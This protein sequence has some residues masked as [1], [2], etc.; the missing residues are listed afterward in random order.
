MTL[1]SSIA[2]EISNGKSQQGP[3]AAVCLHVQVA[4]TRTFE[5]SD[6]GETLERKVKDKEFERKAGSGVFKGAVT[7]KNE[8]ESKTCKE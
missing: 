4:E 7:W 1:A 6:D 5:N 8:A 3:L 2:G